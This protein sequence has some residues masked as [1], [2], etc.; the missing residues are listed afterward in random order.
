MNEYDLRESRRRTRELYPVL[1]DAHGNVIDGFHRLEADPGW[2]RKTLE[3]IRTPAQL[4]LAR[5]VANTHRRTVSREER[6]EQATRLAQALLAEGVPRA[7]IVSTIAELTTFSERYVRGLL[8]DEYKMMSKARFAEPS[9]ADLAE[10]ALTVAEAAAATEGE[11]SEDWDEDEW[12]DVS[13]AEAPETISTIPSKPVEE[14]VVEYLRRHLKPDLGYLTWDVARRYDLIQSEARSIIEKIRAD[15]WMPARR[16]GPARTETEP[17]APRN[18][19]CPL[20]G[21]SGAD[22]GFVQMRMEALR[23]FDPHLPA[24]RWIE[25]ALKL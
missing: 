7:K 11:A 21:R 5:I 22:L 15:G 3:H 8:P 6:S 18:V 13:D 16:A 19:K 20:C 4:W 23:A 1:V 12:R 9:S 17:E 25:E 2:E 14:C 24:H 10:G